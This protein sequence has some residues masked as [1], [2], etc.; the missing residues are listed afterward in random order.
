MVF[1]S[2]TTFRGIATRLMPVAALAIL[3]AGMAAPV[4][5]QDP[6]LV[7]VQY[8]C[9][10]Y[11]RITNANAVPVNVTWD[12]YQT[13]DN[14]AVT[15]PAKWAPY[16]NSE[17]YV[18]TPN[19]GSLRLK[20]GGKVIATKGNGGQA[21]PA[22]ATM[23][24]WSP[25][26]SWWPKHVCGFNGCNDSSVAIAAN[27]LPNGKVMT[28]GRRREGEEPVI[29]DPVANTFTQAAVPDSDLFCSGHTMLADGRIMIA[30]GNR[31]FPYNDGTG[32]PIVAFY[33]WQTDTW[34]RGTDMEVGRWYPTAVT[35]ANGNILVVSGSDTLGGSIVTQAI[36]DLYTPA[37]ARTTLTAAS[38]VLPLYPRLFVAPNGKV[39]YAGEAPQSM[40]FNTTTNLWETGPFT[41]LG[42][43][44]DYGS[45]VMYDGKVMYVGGGQPPTATTEVIDLNAGSP[46]W[47]VA[48]SL[49]SGAR[50]QM[51]ATLLADGKILAT[52]GSGGSPGFNPGAPA[53]YDAEMFDPVTE[54]WTVMASMN[55][56][57]FY[58][59][60]ALLLTDGRLIAMGSGEP[61]PD[62]HYTDDSTRNAEIYSPPYLYNPDGTLTQRP[63]ITSLST[64]TLTYGGAVTINTPNGS[65][66]IRVNLIR[67]GTVTH[68][69]NVGQRLNTL[70]FGTSSTTVTATMPASANLAPPGYFLIFIIDNRGVPSLG[71]IIWLH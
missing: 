46:S 58:H 59:N 54:N 15:L 11:F 53:R 32:P 37:G 67:L 48:G 70:A 3:S 21:C 4:S 28:W 29:W 62:A 5:A 43:N 33:N 12:I 61:S 64:S 71:Q 36:P 19:R 17:T 6:S 39:F 26:F 40:W 69:F 45:A 25:R 1:S 34:T 55:R 56:A 8:R 51:N 20:F 50:R 66:I 52:G 7:K 27:L 30:G 44:R 65:N 9:G 35:L 42:I 57:R 60:T 16:A 13:G 18:N 24:S 14:G 47:H 10:N 31:S 68:A 22:Q 63:V 41:A 23:G 2:A 38:L 49:I